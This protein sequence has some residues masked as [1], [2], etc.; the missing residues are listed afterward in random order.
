MMKKPSRWYAGAAVVSSLLLVACGSDGKGN[1]VPSATTSTISGTA[2]TGCAD[3]GGQH[4]VA[5]PERWVG[6]RHDGRVQEISPSPC[7]RRTCRAPSALSP[8]GGGQSHFSVASG[9]GSVTLPIFRR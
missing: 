9:S 8:A 2:A 4:H 7:R 6:E 5:L 1:T 3:G